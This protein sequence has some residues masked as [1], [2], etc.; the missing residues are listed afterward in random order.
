MHFLRDIQSAGHETLKRLR[1]TSA[2]SP[3]GHAHVRSVTKNSNSNGVPMTPNFLADIQS[4]DQKI[5]LRSALIPRRNQSRVSVDDI[6]NSERSLVAHLQKALSIMRRNSGLDSPC[7]DNEADSDDSGWNETPRER[8]ESSSNNNKNR[9]HK[10]RKSQTFF[11][12]E[13]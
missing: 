2:A 7:P 12:A 13:L 4:T 3:G 9:A 5:R 1:S 8:R 6:N 11:F 10:R